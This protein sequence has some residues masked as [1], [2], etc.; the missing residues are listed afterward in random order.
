MIPRR[1]TGLIVMLAVAL[2]IGATPA[3]D[4]RLLDAARRGDVTAVRSALSDGADPNAAEGDGL[5]ALHIAA[6]QGN[7]QIARLLID[8]RANV[9]AKTRLGE[10]TPLHLAAEGAHVSVVRVFLE[11][12][13]DV[14][15]ITTNTGVTPLHLAAKA[16]NGGGT[17]RE[18][19]QHG[20][21][22]NVPE[23]SAGQTP[24]M[25]AASY[26][27]AA[28]VRELLSDGAN[29]AIRTEVVDVLRRMAIDIAAKERF[30]DA[31]TEIRRNSLEGTDRALT[32]AENHA[33]IEV[34]RE[35]LA[36][37]EEIAKLLANFHEDDLLI[38]GPHWVMQACED[39]TRTC[40]SHMISPLTISRP[41][42]WETLVGKT[43][44]MTALLHA[45]RD[46]RI[47]A[48]DALIDGGADIDQVSGDGSSPLVLALLNGQFDIAMVLIERGADVNLVAHTDG[49]SPLFAVLQ[50]RWSN[51]TR[52]PQP[53]AHD[54]QGT[55]HLQVLNALLE[56]GADPNV[57]LYKHLWYWEH[58]GPRGAMGLELKGATPFWRAAFAQDVDAMRALA[59]YGA[60]PHVPT[61]WP[62]LG[63]RDYRMQDGR[64]D[65]DAGIPR[66][67][68]APNVYPLHAAAGSGQLGYV[69]K[70]VNRV[71]HNFLAAV[72]FLVEEQ[73]VDAKLTDSWGYTAL[74][75][76][77]ALGDNDLVEYLMS[78]GVDVNA[79]TVLG[80][81]PV[82]LSGPGHAGFRVRPTYPETTALLQSFGAQFHCGDVHFKGTGHYCKYSGL[83]PF[84]AISVNVPEE[85]VTTTPEDF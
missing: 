28:A 72:K 40:S 63:M 23:T 22:V 76:A 80:Q 66:D 21:P 52:H 62:E 58:S 56:A 49:V 51:Y 57:R 27:S 6:K 7:S 30:R 73:G 9:E 16:L 34:Q 38:Q 68:G 19:L 11:A 41:P 3:D 12:G 39:D 50:T 18:L 61:V 43:G 70:S 74:H 44:G 31:M 53:R 48:A 47:E 15:A 85:A 20:A 33:A 42:R 59:A 75:Y 82:D 77:A 25:F 54:Q 24:L 17:V 2:L 8:A 36:S 55:E 69:P 35:F 37:D 65:D 1:W 67:E 84:G 71:P 13:A 81:A 78:K 10:Y 26:G 5:T 46:G 64:F 4:A 29:P 45:A 32:T 60:D 79:L 83:E 14:R